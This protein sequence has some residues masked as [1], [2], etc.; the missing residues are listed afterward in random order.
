MLA[1]SSNPELDDAAAGG[2]GEPLDMFWRRYNLALLD[3]LALQ[4]RQDALQEENEMLQTT[5]QQYVDGI[6]VTDETLRRT[7]P[8]LVVKGKPPLSHKD[9]R[10]RSRPTVVDGNH[11]LQT[12]RLNT[13]PFFG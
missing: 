13:V 1:G 11:M 3:K 7:N 9:A 8:L 10:G 5:I 12:G 4:E 6:T 2:P